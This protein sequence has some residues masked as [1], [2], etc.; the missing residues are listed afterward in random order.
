MKK[1]LSGHFVTIEINENA[2]TSN[3]W[4]QNKGRILQEGSHL[5]NPAE[6]LL[7]CVPKKALLLLQLSRVT[8]GE[9]VNFDVVCP[10]LFG[11]FID[12]AFRRMPEQ[13]ALREV[14]LVAKNIE[15]PVRRVVTEITRSI[16][17]RFHADDLYAGN[18]LG[19]VGNLIF[20]E[21]TN[22]FCASGYCIYGIG[23]QSIEAEPA[24]QDAFLST[25]HTRLVAMGYAQAMALYK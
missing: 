22:R 2:L 15:S 21:A 1:Y 11:Y 19:I 8:S 6:E 7:A 18:Y 3:R 17:R 13:E 24:Y 5:L 23:I 25:H 14:K 16:F 20:K 9:G 10:V 12:K 4:L